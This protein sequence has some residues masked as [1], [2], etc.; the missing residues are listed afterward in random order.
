[1][2]GRIIG[3][4]GYEQAN[5][6]TLADN[7]TNRVEHNV[8]EQRRTNS[9]STVVSCT[10]EVGGMSSISTE[11]RQVGSAMLLPPV[12]GFDWWVGLVLF[13]RNREGKHCSAVACAALDLHKES[14]AEAFSI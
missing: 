5:L 8:I 11:R 4:G 14:T 12:A 9:I 3:A 2:R 13:D 7:R 10:K 1:M 6:Q